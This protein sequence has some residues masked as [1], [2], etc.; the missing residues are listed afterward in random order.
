MEIS[1]FLK[2]V[3]DCDAQ[4]SILLIFDYQCSL[5]IS[6]GL[7][8]QQEGVEWELGKDTGGYVRK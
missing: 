7:T 6:L 5:A 1:S 3:F 8:K 2:I 4:I